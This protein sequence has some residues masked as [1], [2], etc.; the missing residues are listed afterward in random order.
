M[1][2]LFVLCTSCAPAAVARQSEASERA[3]ELFTASAASVPSASAAGPE[4]TAAIVTPE[5]ALFSYREDDI[6]LAFTPPSRVT[7]LSRREGVCAYELGNSGNM[8]SGAEVEAAFRNADV[9]AAIAK[10]S[11]FL[12]PEDLMIG[13]ELRVGSDRIAWTPFCGGICVNGPPG[14]VGLLRVLHVVATNARAVCSSP[15]SAA[16][17]R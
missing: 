17:Q 7:V 14:V 1:A 3:A 13:A 9:A 4:L 12:P 10:S 8:Y 5:G 15:A 6:L 2:A 16:V 11:A